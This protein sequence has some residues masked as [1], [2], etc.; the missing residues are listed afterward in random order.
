M[1]NIVTIAAACASLTTGF[2]NANTNEIIAGYESQTPIEM[3][4][5]DKKELKHLGSG[6]AIGALFGGPVG[7]VAG[8][9]I[10]DITHEYKE[11]QVQHDQLAESHSKLKSQV[12]NL[13]AELADAKQANSMMTQ[14]L[15]QSYQ[16]QAAQQQDLLGLVHGLTL[17]IGF[18]TKSHTVEPYYQQTIAHIAGLL[19]KYS[20]IHVN[21]GGYADP[22]GKASE[23]L[24]LSEKRAKAVKSALVEQGVAQQQITTVAHGEKKLIADPKDQAAYALERRVEINIETR[25]KDGVAQR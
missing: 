8:A 7:A 4:Q 18:K 19:K 15:S 25:S 21:I 20:N 24:A 16:Q 2:A 11:Q 10:G 22:R 17:S 14:Q 3:T 9:I 6:A 13:Q 1:K 23:N 12:E 5:T